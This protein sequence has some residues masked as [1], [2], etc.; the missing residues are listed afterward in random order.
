MFPIQR[1]PK[2]RLV[3]LGAASLGC[4]AS[5]F[6][7]LA[8]SIAHEGH[9]DADKSPAVSS[10]YPRVAARS[11]LYEIVGILKDGQLTIF[12]DD[13]ITNEP[14][15][16][17]TLRVT[18]GDS[19]AIEAGAQSGIYTAALPDRKLTGSVEVIFSVA[20]RKGDD[21]L[22]DSLTLP[23]AVV[24]PEKHRSNWLSPGRTVIAFTFAGLGFGLLAGYLRRRGRSVAAM[25]AAMVTGA[26][27]ILAAIS[28][29]EN[30]NSV[31]DA[32]APAARALSDA[33]RRLQDGSA[34]AAKPTQRLLDV[35]T[36]VAE[37]QTVRPALNLIGRVI[38]DPNRSSIVQSIYGGRVVPNERAIPRI[39]QSVSKGDV[40]IQIEPHLPVADRTTILEKVGEIE[41][42]IAVAENKL[43]RLR[44]LAE[45][46]AVPQ[47][48]VNDL[49]SELEG[50]RARRETT[51]NS[52]T[53]FEVLRAS[54]DGIITSA[55]VVPGQVIQPQ[56]VLFQI[57]DPKN[58]WVEALAYD[59]IGLNEPGEATAIGHNGPPIALS[60]LGT[61]RAL[62][63]H[64]SVVHFAIPEPPAGLNIGQ[65]LTVMV[66]RG[67]PVAGLIFPSDAV[68][69]SSNGENIVWLHTAPER[70]EPKPV[71][72]F[73]VDATRVIVAAGINE[74]ERVVVRGADLIN[75]IR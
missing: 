35:R 8:I 62:R 7:G 70:F 5:L 28:V 29:G 67:A 12:I 46:G 47:G 27:V 30:R 74:R 48:Q 22:V 15:P 18:I 54:T 38:A 16:D 73:P 49:E 32:S 63:Q 4:L 42:L 41:Q 21:L 37:P 1:R 53:G 39:G 3:R 57:A 19:P 68:V 25:S 20:A 71:R 50:L 66:Q 36:A 13:A 55:K 24:V 69:R 56:D 6:L 40:L 11:D 60:F 64:A 2:G 33:P 26:C 44:P 31:S 58:L 23:Q 59:D 72:V 51:R 9:G 34:F 14:V 75:Q 10:A 17:A 65:P 43:R 45:R 52:R 61:S